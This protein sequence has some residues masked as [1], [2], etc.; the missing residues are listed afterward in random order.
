[1]NNCIQDIGKRKPI[2]CVGQSIQTCVN[3]AFMLLES[4]LAL[5]SFSAALCFTYEP[6]VSFT[7]FFM[8]FKTAGKSQMSSMIK[9][10]S[11]VL[12]EF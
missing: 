3:V 11:F 6:G 8:L 10:N 4:V 9:K 1:M 12:E 2:V 5:E 7:G